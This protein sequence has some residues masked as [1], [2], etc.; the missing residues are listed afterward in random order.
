[1]RIPKLIYAENNDLK[2]LY[3]QSIFIFLHYAYI[4]RMSLS[5]LK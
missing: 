1:M 4:S 5:T 2:M 3:Q